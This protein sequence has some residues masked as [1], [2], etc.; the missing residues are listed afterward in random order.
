MKVVDRV[1]VTFC[2]LFLACTLVPAAIAGSGSSN[3]PAYEI[4][5]QIREVGA[6]QS[7][8]DSGD[9]QDSADA[10]G[11]DE[12]RE[13][14]EAE[15]VDDDK[16]PAFKLLGSSVPAGETR[17]LQWSGIESFVGNVAS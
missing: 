14:V 2:C 11:A 5:I 17:R 9:T 12:D 3:T 4:E 1:F 7:G 10:P 8:E 15:P 13:D 6:E 16:R